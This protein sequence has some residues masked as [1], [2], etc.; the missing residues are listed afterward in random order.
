MSIVRTGFELV[1]GRRGFDMISRCTIATAVFALLCT[2]TVAAQVTVVSGDTPGRKAGLRPDGLFLDVGRVGPAHGDG[3]FSLGAGVGLGTLLSRY[4]DFSLGVRTW[5]ADIDRS[6]FGSDASGTFG[7]VAVSAD[8]TLPLVKVLGLR[9]YVG[10]GLSGHFAGADIPADRSLEDAISGFNAGTQAVIGLATTRRG[11]GLRAQVRRDFVDDVGGTTISLGAGWW[12]KTRAR[13]A[14]DRRVQVGAPAPAAVQAAGAPAPAA[15]ADPSILADLVRALN[16]L[17][18]ENRLIRAELDSLHRRVAATPAATSAP[19]TPPE[20][21]APP[22]PPRDPVSEL[23]R[24]L[25]ALTMPVGLRMDGV[26]FVVRPN[27][28]FPNGGSELNLEARE[29]LRRFASIILRYPEAAIEIQ[30]H[31]D[32][33]GSA[34]ANRD[35]SERRALSVRE[36]LRDLG[37]SPVRLSAIGYGSTQP[38]AENTTAAGRARNRRVDIVITMHDESRGR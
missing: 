33:T 14:A 23:G 10:T 18:Q 15:A 31:T 1:S 27:L 21:T 37:V 35:L 17:K 9:S 13:P 11:W 16:H 25:A 3:A 7:D 5:S 30:G 29:E 6:D 38:V 19:A 12:P 26:S 4:L 32:A 20:T 8:L 36:E 34:A 24:S 28:Q 22:A 2:S